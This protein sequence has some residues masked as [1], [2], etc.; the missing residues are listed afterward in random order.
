[1]KCLYRRSPLREEPIYL[2]AALKSGGDLENLIL[3]IISIIVVI[4]IAYLMA[5]TYSSNKSNLSDWF[6]LLN[7]I[8]SI[9]GSLIALAT[10]VVL[11]FWRNE[12]NAAIDTLLDYKATFQSALIATEQEIEHELSRL[13]DEV[14]IRFNQYM[15]GKK[16]SQ[17]RLKRLIRHV[18]I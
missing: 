3:F 17:Q 1:M 6:D 16:W 12:I 5:I 8:A 4:G 11:A 2:P 13:K 10:I 7:K 15:A 14:S 18:K 9:T